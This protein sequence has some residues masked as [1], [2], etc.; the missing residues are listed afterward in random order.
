MNYR[1]L[2]GDIRIGVWTG[3]ILLAQ[4]GLGI[5]IATLPAHP[6]TRT[7]VIGCNDVLYYASH[8][9]PE[10]LAALKAQLSAAQLAAA[11][12]CL[13]KPR[14]S[15]P[16]HR[17]PT[18]VVIP[19]PRPATDRDREVAP[20]VKVTIPPPLRIEQTPVLQTDKAPVLQSAPPQSK[21][22]GHTMIE[23]VLACVGVAAIVLFILHHTVK[24]AKALAAWR[25]DAKAAKAVAASRVDNLEAM[26]KQLV[27]NQT[28]P[29]SQPAPVAATGATGP[30]GQTPPAA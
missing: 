16:V 28:A 22:E 11:K 10:Q 30:T 20:S 14:V 5:L 4:A 9:T 13:E 15:S 29:A 27:A 7:P 24:G 19:R 6:E 25:T 23:L 1:E 2:W 12:K 17:A 18:H 26:L 3:G 21:P 8:S